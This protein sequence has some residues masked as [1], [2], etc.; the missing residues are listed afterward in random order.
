MWS[1]CNLGGIWTLCALINVAWSQH[2]SQNFVF[3]Q[4]QLPTFAPS[5]LLWKKKITGL[6]VRWI[7]FTSPRRCLLCTQVF[8]C[9]TPKYKQFLT[10]APEWK[11]WSVGYIPDYNQL[12]CLIF[13]VDLKTY[14]S[15]NCAA[16]PPQG[17]QRL[18]RPPAHRQETSQTGHLFFRNQII[19]S[20]LK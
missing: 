18:H 5:E 12:Y 4:T 15:D 10:K 13:T 19:T 17:V 3:I 20:E 2:G 1:Y 7:L 16:P 11:G 9:S 8:I 14:S 6:T